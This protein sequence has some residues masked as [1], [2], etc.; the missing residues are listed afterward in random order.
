[1][2]LAQNPERLS[3]FIAAKRYSLPIITQSTDEHLCQVEQ[4]RWFELYRPLPDFLMDTLLKSGHFKIY[5]GMIMRRITHRYLL[6]VP[7]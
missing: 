4:N 2:L 5:L 6:L 3:S 7:L 1:M